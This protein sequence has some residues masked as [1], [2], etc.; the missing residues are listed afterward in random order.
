MRFDELRW[1]FVDLL[2][3]MIVFGCLCVVGLLL[4]FVVFVPAGIAFCLKKAT[5]L[6]PS[7]ALCR[8]PC[9]RAKHAVQWIYTQ[10]CYERVFENEFDDIEFEYITALGEGRT[11]KARWVVARG[12]FFVAKAVWTH[13]ASSAVGTVAS[14]LGKLIRGS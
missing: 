5:A 1:V 14:G 4:N 9:S 13:A 6:F 7:S 3:G 11:I 8:P 12:Y 2:L 10:K